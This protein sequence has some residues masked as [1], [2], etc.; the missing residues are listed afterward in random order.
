MTITVTQNV[1]NL[2]YFVPI[3][4]KT[5]QNKCKVQSSTFFN[6]QSTYAGAIVSLQ[7]K[8]T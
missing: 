6:W 7:V 3:Q 5:L 1:L 4:I 2:A 8:V